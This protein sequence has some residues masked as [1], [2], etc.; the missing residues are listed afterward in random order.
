MLLL[1]MIK[2][3]K[4][5]FMGKISEHLKKLKNSPSIFEK[6]VFFHLQLLHSLTAC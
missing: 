3:K 6:F 4:V 5:T 1:S 2:V